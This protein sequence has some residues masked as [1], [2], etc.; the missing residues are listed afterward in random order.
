MAATVAAV[1]TRHVRFDHT[2]LADVDESQVLIV[3]GM[4]AGEGPELDAWG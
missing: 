2:G 4:P 1:I 3:A